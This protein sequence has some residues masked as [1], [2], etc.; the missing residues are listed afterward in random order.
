MYNLRKAFQLQFE[1]LT[2]PYP[3]TAAAR[4]DE[5]FK[6][7][8]KFQK[9]YPQY[10]SVLHETFGPFLCRLNKMDL[11]QAYYDKEEYKKE[12]LPYRN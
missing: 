12:V 3:Y 9:D 8:N 6:E 5:V 11:T 4:F 7:L 10:K 2:D 1:N